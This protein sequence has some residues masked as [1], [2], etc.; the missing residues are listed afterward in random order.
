MPKVIGVLLSKLALCTNDNV[1]FPVAL[2]TG[3]IRIFSN[4]KARSDLSG[5]C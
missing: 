1:D 4:R 3:N 5:R 2:I